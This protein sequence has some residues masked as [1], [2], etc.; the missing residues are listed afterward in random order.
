MSV[1]S[2]LKL[3]LPPSSSNFEKTRRK[4]KNKVV[5]IILTDHDATDSD[6]SSDEAH[7][8]TTRKKL[9]R[10]ITQITMHL[11]SPYSSTTISSSSSPSPS[12]STSSSTFSSLSS[13]SLQQRTRPCKRPK[14]PQLPSAERHRNRFRGVRQRPWGRWAAEIRDPTQRKRVWLGTFDTAEEA[15]TEYDRA[16]LKL[17]GPNAVTNFPVS[18][19]PEVTAVDDG[20]AAFSDAVALSPTSVLPYDGYSTPFDGFRFVDA[21]GFDIA[22]E[23]PLSLTDVDVN[24]VMLTCQRL[25]DAKEDEAFGEFDLDEFITWPY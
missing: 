18:S 22:D 20:V 7:Q 14:K 11:P 2:R 3:K 12:P 25:D 13:D 15:A 5:R 23:A 21:F 10:E 1:Q 6:S 4:T 8:N 16:A 24:S 9:K 19:P 17:K